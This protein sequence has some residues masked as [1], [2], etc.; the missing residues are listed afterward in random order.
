M[1]KLILLISLCF[2]LTLSA[3]ARMSV[4]H[5]A[6]GGH[7]DYTAD[8]NCMGA[9]LMS[10]SAD[11]TDISGEGGTLTE[12]TDDDIPSVATSPTGYTTTSRDF[13]L[14]D[15]DWLEHADGK[16]TD[17]TGDDVTVVLWGK[18]EADPG[19]DVHAAM[20]GGSGDESYSLKCDDG[21]DGWEFRTSTDG[22]TVVRATG[23]TACQHTNWQFVAGVYNGTDIR[24]YYNGL[25]DSNGAD[26]PK[27][28]TGNLH[29]ADAGFYV[30]AYGAGAWDWWDGL[31]SQVAVFNRALTAAEIL[32][33][34]THGI[35]GA[36]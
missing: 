10:S 25:L 32:E 11:E 22:T 4:M 7:T 31:I 20:K 21:S 12:S 17:I 36:Q 1:K 30:G 2:T 13:E 27:A 16:S 5:I 14:G 26:N 15:Q 35:Q 24:I 29:D 9:W 19:A 6:A 23:A 28:Q 8:A 34:Y 33:I 3:D 18:L